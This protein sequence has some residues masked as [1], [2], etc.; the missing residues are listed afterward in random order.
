MKRLTLICAL[1]TAC[2]SLPSAPY[3]RIESRAE[4]EHRLAE[5]EE[6]ESHWLYIVDDH[7]LCGIIPKQMVDDGFWPQLS[8]GQYVTD[9][10][11]VRYTRPTQGEV[12]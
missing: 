3:A 4:R 11:G 6:I 1:M 8:E 7:S 2:T 10:R 9:T 5:A 12:K